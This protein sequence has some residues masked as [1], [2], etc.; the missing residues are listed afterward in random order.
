MQPRSLDPMQAAATRLLS[1]FARARPGISAVPGVAGAGVLRRPFAGGL[2][3][4]MP[5][6][7][8]PV[9]RLQV[10]TLPEP[11][12]PPAVAVWVRGFASSGTPPPPAAPAAPPASG[13][14]EN[15]SS[16]S[17]EPVVQ[18]VNQD[19]AGTRVRKPSD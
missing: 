7:V 17:E 5:T 1:A 19:Q 6:S 13:D 10:R 8:R 4:A 11:A 2:H 15:A 18:V 3:N 9:S 12:R 14:G 16:A